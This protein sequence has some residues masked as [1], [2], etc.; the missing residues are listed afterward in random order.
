MNGSH[1]GDGSLAEHAAP[2]VALICLHADP[3]T[4]AGVGEGGGTHSYLRELLRFLTRCKTDHILLTRWADP[5]LPEMQRTSQC[6]WLRRLRIGAPGPIDKRLLAGFH[7]TT[8]AAV[9]D[10]LDEFGTPGLLHSVY[11]NSGQAAMDVSAERGLPFVHTVISNGWRREASGQHDQP[12]ERVAI[13]RRVFQAAHRIFSI[14]SQE[15]DDLIRA[16]GVPAD[17]IVVV[18]RPVGDAFRTPARDLLGRPRAELQKPG[19]L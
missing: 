10:A 6:G 7:S 13:E 4:P 3:T 19:G 11:W 9:S 1:G 15:R 12:P 5:D 16:Y 8:V 18:G 2:R 14:C 17:R